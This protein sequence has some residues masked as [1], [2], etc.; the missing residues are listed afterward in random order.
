VR[1]KAATSMN[2]GQATIKKADG[3]TVFAGR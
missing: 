2:V 3:T 1:A